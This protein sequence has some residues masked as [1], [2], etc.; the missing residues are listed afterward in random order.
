[1][2]HA[3][4]EKEDERGASYGSPRHGERRQATHEPARVPA[5]QAAQNMRGELEN[6][7]EQGTGYGLSRGERLLR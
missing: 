1:M 7:I 5:Q 6:I 4:G 3:S 2:M